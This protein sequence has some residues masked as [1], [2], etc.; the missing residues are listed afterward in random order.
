MPLPP[1]SCTAPHRPPKPMPLTSHG[2]RPAHTVPSPGYP[3]PERSHSQ[4]AVSIPPRSEPLPFPC[5]TFVENQKNRGRPRTLRVPTHREK[6]RTL[7]HCFTR[8]PQWPKKQVLLRGSF[9]FSLRLDCSL[10]LPLPV[11]FSFSLSAAHSPARS[12]PHAL[13][14]CLGSSFRSFVWGPFL[15]FSIRSAQKAEVSHFLSQLST[16]SCKATR[17]RASYPASSCSS[18]T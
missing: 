5:F 10:A 14:A 13:R 11:S 7:A 18:W 2:L 3:T 8:N 16:S 6:S 17:P 1:I 15:S 9:G 4:A 12:T